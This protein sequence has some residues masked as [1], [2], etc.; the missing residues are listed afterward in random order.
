MAKGIGNGIPLGAVA[1][2]HEIASSLTG[3]LFF[4]TYGGNPLSSAIGREVLKII[5]EENLQYN[6]LVMGKRLK[7]GLEELS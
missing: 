7:D 2:S 3:K 4:N 5:D 1:T 6:C